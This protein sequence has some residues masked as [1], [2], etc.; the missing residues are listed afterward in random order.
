MREDDHRG[1]GIDF[2]HILFEPVAL[3][4]AATPQTWNRAV[5]GHEPV[6]PLSGRQVR[7]SPEVGRQDRIETDEMHTLVIQ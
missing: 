4:L 6:A 1:F 3:R 2:G 5:Q 7:S